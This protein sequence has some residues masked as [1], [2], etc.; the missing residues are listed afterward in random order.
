MLNWDKPKNLFAFILGSYWSKGLFAVF[1]IP[2]FWQFK[3]DNDL[4]L[5]QNNI[6]RTPLNCQEVNP[7]YLEVYS[8]E[9]EDY[10][11]S[12]CQLEQNFYYHRQSKVNPDDRVL[13]SAQAVDRGNVFQAN[14]GRITY[15]AG[16]NGDRYY[17][18]IVQSDDEII[19][20]PELELPN[21]VQSLYPADETLTENQS[22][23]K[24]NASLE[25]ASPEEN[26]EQVLICTSEKSAFHPRL[27]SWP[28]FIGKSMIT[29]SSYAENNGLDFI[30]SE[31]TPNIASI[32][33]ENGVVVN[34]SIA[35]P[36]K[37]IEQVCIQPDAG[38]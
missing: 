13:V 17:S 3:L 33:T 4:L 6:D 9:I 12:I 11:I 1:A 32:I 26:S 27:N 14:D 30:Y 35:D 2:S 18:S 20:E 16:R 22:E 36:K 25:L 21:K 24:D 28:K 37:T 29:A 5:A 38:E 31:R 8:F 34:L 7:A 15:F 19:F 10:Q 23:P